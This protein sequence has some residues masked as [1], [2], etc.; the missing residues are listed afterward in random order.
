MYD[1][2][3][4]DSARFIA[5]VVVKEAREADAE[6]NAHPQLLPL[7]HLEKCG[8]DTVAFPN[9]GEWDW[10]NMKFSWQDAKFEEEKKE[11]LL[12]RT[13]TDTVLEC[14]TSMLMADSLETSMRNALRSMGKY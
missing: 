11:V 9:D 4:L 14:V 7:R 13:A 2:R 6:N 3:D 1:I 8:M 5:G 12:S 10:M